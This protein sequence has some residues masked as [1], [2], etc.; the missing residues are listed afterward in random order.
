VDQSEDNYFP[1]KKVPVKKSMN[2]LMLN[3]EFPPIGG[4]AANANL[5]LLRQF[6]DIPEIRIDVLTAGLGRSTTEEQFASN[7][8]LYKVGLKKKQL[9]YWRKSE[10]L[11]WL[12]KANKMYRQLIRENNYDLAHAFF[13]FPTGWICYRHRKSLPYILSLRGSDVP[14][15]NQRLSLDYRLLGGLFRRIWTQAAKVIANSRGLQSLA[16]SFMPDLDIKV[17]PNGVDMA[18]NYPAAFKELATPVKL[19]AVGRLIQR[20]RVD[21]LIGAVKALKEMDIE[22]HLSIAG[23]GNLTQELQKQAVELGLSDRI[24][25][26][27]RV[28]PDELAK[29]YRESDLFVMSSLH[30]GMSNAM[31][32]AMASGL[33]IVTANC[34]GVEE[35]IT[36]NGII[37]KDRTPKAFAQAIADIFKKPDTYRAMAD[38]STIRAK[39]FSWSSVADEYMDCYKNI[40]VP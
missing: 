27:S 24:S 17:I 11:T 21:V 10:V 35:L 36:D 9:H 20:K 14:G 38:T 13:G 12:F 23:D 29:L 40:R 16:N 25:F 37:V 15:Y 2:I 34:E 19:L 28:E 3:Y 26:L 32:E 1:E 4:G 22:A 18:T 8:R 7:I 39:D 30:E 33:P 6:A 31:L 5:Q